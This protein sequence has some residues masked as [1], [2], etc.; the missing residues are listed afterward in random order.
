MPRLKKST[1]YFIGT[2][3]DPLARYFVSNFPLADG[4]F[5]EVMMDCI[6]VWGSTYK[7]FKSMRLKV[8]NALDVI[9]A[10]FSFRTNE[11]IFYKFR[12]WV[13][14]R[15]VISKENMIGLVLPLPKMPPH[16]P[17][18][19]PKNNHWKKSANLYNELYKGKGNNNHIFALKDYR[20]AIADKSENAFLFAYRSIEDICRA[21]TG[22]DDVDKHWD[23]MH[24]VLGTSKKIVDPL[25]K[26][27]KRVRHGNMAHV[28]VRRAKKRREKLISI[29]KQ[30]IEKELKRTF[31]KF[32]N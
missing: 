29:A 28:V 17:V 18:H 14:A 23:D 10:G 21:V 5:L 2:L 25:L 13:E 12:N 19:S 22:Q 8:E 6:S 4:F 20:S 9:T 24:A 1:Y 7:D 15:K 31:P 26:V 3:S 27:S 30:V 32:I 16:Y 11:P